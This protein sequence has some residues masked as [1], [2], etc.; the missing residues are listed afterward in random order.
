MP[1]ISSR[2]VPKGLIWLGVS[3]MLCGSLWGCSR[4]T[5]TDFGSGCVGQSATELASQ[6]TLFAETTGGTFVRV[7]KDDCSDRLP[8]IAWIEY[9]ATSQTELKRLSALKRTV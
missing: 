3:L 9:G 6:A 2:P 4:V 5:P 8:A 7:Y 1:G